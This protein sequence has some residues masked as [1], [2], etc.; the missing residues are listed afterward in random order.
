M[1]YGVLVCLNSDEFGSSLR[2]WK[3]SP[4]LIDPPEIVPSMF[5]GRT[6]RTRMARPRPEADPGAIGAPDFRKLLHEY[7]DG[8]GPEALEYLGVVLGAW[9]SDDAWMRISGLQASGPDDPGVLVFELPEKLQLAAAELADADVPR[10]A[11]SWLEAIEKTAPEYPWPGTLFDQQQYDAWLSQL[12]SL[13][14]KARDT[15]RVMYIAT[16]IG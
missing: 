14:R 10:I 12:V 6:L 16:G 13:A 4:P 3:R 15:G 11:S 1:A 7:V 5:P 8:L 2:G 9:D